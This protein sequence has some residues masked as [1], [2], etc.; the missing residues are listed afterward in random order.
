MKKSVR[1]QQYIALLS[2]LLFVAKLI[3]WR[4]TDS[5]TVLTDALESIVNVVA[6]FLGLFSVTLAAKPSD[7]N[8]PY[9]KQNPNCF[10]AH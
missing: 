7:L 10:E 2:V 4:L 5:V 8:H 6:G 9:L 3:A 1:I